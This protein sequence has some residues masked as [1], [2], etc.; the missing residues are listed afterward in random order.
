MIDTNSAAIDA[1]T[2]MPTLI[3]ENNIMS[4]PSHELIF[5]HAVS[6][7]NVHMIANQTIIPPVTP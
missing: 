1:G 3:T 7:D 6:F 2:I 4:P 5:K